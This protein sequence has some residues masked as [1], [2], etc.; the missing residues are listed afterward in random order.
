[1]PRREVAVLV[2][3]AVVGQEALPVDGLHLATGADGAGVE[4]VA[5]EERDADERDDPSRLARQPLKRAL[6]GSDEAAAQQEVLRRV[7]G[8]GELREEEDLDAEPLRLLDPADDALAV[9]VEIADDGVDLREAE[10][11]FAPPSRKPSLPVGRI[12]VDRGPS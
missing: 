3:D 9:A 1:V 6:G 10:S 12:V 4:E 5:V 7:P 8:D 11:Q 2:E